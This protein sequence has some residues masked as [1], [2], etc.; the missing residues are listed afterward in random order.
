ME[1]PK[2]IVIPS[3]A[4]GLGTHSTADFWS[5]ADLQRSKPN[6][7]ILTLTAGPASGLHCSTPSCGENRKE[8]HP[9]LQ[10]Y[11]QASQQVRRSL[12]CALL[13]SAGFLP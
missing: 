8:P 2:C 7:W 12:L 10:F 3:E 1:T 5:R 6:T 11:G 9:K 13:H 4:G